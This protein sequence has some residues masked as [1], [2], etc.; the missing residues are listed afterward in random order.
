MI[1]IDT[2]IERWFVRTKNILQCTTFIGLFKLRAVIYERLIKRLTVQADYMFYKV[3]NECFASLWRSL[4]CHKNKPHFD[5]GCFYGNI[6]ND[7]H[8]FLKQKS[9]ERFASSRKK[10]EKCLYHSCQE[11][12]LLTPLWV[13]LHT[14]LSKAVWNRHLLVLFGNRA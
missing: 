1:W 6:I 8:C 5:A 4:G 14:G 11:T 2:M 7:E 9:E 12:T 3:G 13:L 10:A